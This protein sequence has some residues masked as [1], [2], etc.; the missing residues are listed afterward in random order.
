MEEDF[1]FHFP[2]TREKF[3]AIRKTSPRRICFASTHAHQP[4]RSPD[5]DS[6]GRLTLPFFNSVG[7]VFED[8]CELKLFRSKY[9][10]GCWRSIRSD[11]EFDIIA[12]WA[13]AQGTRVLLRDCLD[14]SIA[15]DINL[16][17]VEGAPPRY[18]DLGALESLA[19]SAPDEEA[20]AA[21]TDA[22]CNA[23]RGLPLYRDAKLIA[24]VPPQPDKAYDLPQA[25]VARIAA[26]LSIT[27]VTDRFEFAAAKGTVKNASVDQKWDEWAK[28]GLTFKPPL[29][30][31]PAVILVDDKY[32]SGTSINFVASRL[33]AAGAGDILGLCAVKTWRDT[34]NA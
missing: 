21:L 16:I 20:L 32:Q 23:I 2:I 33:R 1:G 5:N 17:E 7:P 11:E 27:D 19:K 9:N 25:L 28:S 6:V 15:L 4:R 34:D 14:S 24:A 22:F 18:T 30:N 31:E 8:H 26:A 13:K 3:D 12:A 10:Q 29:Q